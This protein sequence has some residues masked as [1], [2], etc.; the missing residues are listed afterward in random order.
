M[1]GACAQ[2]DGIVASKQDRL[3]LCEGE[4]DLIAVPRL[5]QQEMQPLKAATRA[6]ACTQD[7]VIF[8]VARACSDKRTSQGLHLG[9]GGKAHK[10]CDK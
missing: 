8:M 7:T 4:A 9:H 2:Q 1:T 6:Q 5:L 10:R 3:H